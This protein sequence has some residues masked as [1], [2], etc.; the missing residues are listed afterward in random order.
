[1]GKLQTLY[2]ILQDTAD[3]AVSGKTVL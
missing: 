2:L 1:M 3:L